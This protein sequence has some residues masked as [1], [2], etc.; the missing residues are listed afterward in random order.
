MII[1]WCLLLRK[2]FY[3][4]NNL[5]SYD[6]LVETI[7]PYLSD[8]IQEQR[9]EGGGDDMQESET[10]QADCGESSN[11]VA[12]LAHRHYHRHQPSPVTDTD[13]IVKGLLYTA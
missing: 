2:P 13:I 4:L 8:V 5:L 10:R 3:K 6:Q 7:L 12:S 9:C 1:G 11:Q